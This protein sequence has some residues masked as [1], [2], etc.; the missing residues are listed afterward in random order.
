MLAHG[1]RGW[2]FIMAGVAGSKQQVWQLEQEAKSSHPQGQAW[3]RERALGVG[4]SIQSQ[5]PPAVMYPS[6]KAAL[7]KSP[8]TVPANRGQ[9]FKYLS[10]WGNIAHSNLTSDSNLYSPSL[11]SV[12]VLKTMT[13]SNSKEKNLVFMPHHSSSLREAMV[14]TWRQEEAM[15]ERCSLS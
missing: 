7:P 1:S 2:E 5:S 8:Q 10:W 12:A 6:S 9:I 11:L 15:E 13:E 14:G 4:Q 3:S